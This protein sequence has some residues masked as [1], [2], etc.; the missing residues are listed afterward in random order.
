[1]KIYSDDKWLHYAPLALYFIQGENNADCIDIT[2]PKK[3][4]DIDLTALSWRISAIST[5]G[6]EATQVLN[7]RLTDKHIILNWRITDDFT[8]VAG[9]LRVVLQG[10]NPAGSIVT[11]FTGN[12]IHIIEDKRGTPPHLEEI[13]QQ[14]LNQ[15]QTLSC[16]IISKGLETEKLFNEATSLLERLRKEGDILEQKTQEVN[17][18][19]AIFIN[20]ILPNITAIGT[21]FDSF[22]EFPKEGN[23]TSLYVDREHNKIHRFDAATKQYVVVGSD[24]LQIKQIDGGNANG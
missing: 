1:M 22:S 8:A 12:P 6:I 4:N 13:S 3:R 18:K 20:D 5:N 9:D 10:V 11:K 7:S 2:I 17:N 19:L 15:I 16:N 21:Q 14:I 23:T 24:Y